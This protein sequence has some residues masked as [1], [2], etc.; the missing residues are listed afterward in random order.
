MGAPL[1]LNHPFLTGLRKWRVKAFENFLVFSLP[2]S[3]GITIAR[4]LH[5]T[6]DWT[7]MLGLD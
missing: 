6:R 1:A 7:S 4:V 3:G 5:G 2:Q